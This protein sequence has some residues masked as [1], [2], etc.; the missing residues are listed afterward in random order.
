MHNGRCLNRIR[1][2][3]DVRRG[4]SADVTLRLCET[5]QIATRES[6]RPMVPFLGIIRVR[7]AP[8]IGS[9]L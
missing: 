2:T 8:S 7:P 9:V 5:E 3:T 1:L 4:K 6:F